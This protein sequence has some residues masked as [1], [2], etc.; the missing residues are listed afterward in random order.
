MPGPSYRPSASNATTIINQETINNIVNQSFLT[1]NGYT[2]IAEILEKIQNEGG[3]TIALGDIGNTPDTT[4][5]DYINSLIGTSYSLDANEIYFFTASTG[6]FD[7]LYLF[8]GGK[9]VTI[10]EGGVQVTALDFKPLL[11]SDRT[12][13]EIPDYSLPAGL[14]GQVH[15]ISEGKNVAPDYTLKRGI[16]TETAQEFTEATTQEISLKEVF[17][18]WDRFVHNSS[19]NLGVSS[20]PNFPGLDDSQFGISKKIWNEKKSWGYD[21]E[22]DR[23]FLTQNFGS[24]SGFVSPKSYSNFILSASLSSPSPDD[25]IMGLVIAFVKDP[26]TGYEHTISVIRNKTGYASQYT[27]AVYLN[28][29]QNRSGLF[30]LSKEILIADGTGLAPDIPEQ[31]GN[32]PGNN[33]RLFVERIGDDFTI[34]TSQFGS[35][36]IDEN[37]TLNFSL[38]DLPELERFRIG[39]KVGFSALSQPNAFFSDVYFTGFNEYILDLQNGYDAPRIFSY[40]FAD[41]LWFEDQNLTYADIWGIN[42]FLK[43]STNG[44]T[45]YLGASEVIKIS[46]STKKAQII[47]ITGSIIDLS[48]PFC[49]YC[50]LESPNTNETFTFSNEVI[51]GKARILI[52]TINEPEIIGATKIEAYNVEFQSG[53]DI[54]IEVEYNGVAVEWWFKNKG[55]NATPLSQIESLPFGIIIDETQNI[56]SEYFGSPAIVK[57]DTG[58]YIM[59]HEV[60]GGANDKTTRV[61]YSDDPDNVDFIQTEIIPNILWGG[62]VKNNSKLYLVGINNYP[63]GGQVVISESVDDGSNWSAPVTV[64]TVPNGYGGWAKSACSYIIKDNHLLI[65]MELRDTSVVRQ[66]FNSACLVIVD[67][68]DILDPVNWY[69]SNAVKLDDAAMEAEGIYNISSPG[70][71]HGIFEGSVVEKS[72]GDLIMMLRLEQEPN[73]NN[74]VYL[75]IIYNAVTPS[76]TTLSTVNNFVEMGGGNVKYTVLWDAVSAK[77]WTVANVNRYKAIDDNRM[78]AM[79]LSS[80]DDCVTWDEYKKVYGFSPTANWQTEA[81]QLGAQYA[82]FI[83]DGN[84]ILIA[85]R[86]AN[87]NAANYHNANILSLIKVKNFRDIPKK[88]FIDAAM[89][90]DENSERLQD[91]NGINLVKDQ[92]KNY[93]SPYMLIS[94]NA[95][96]PIYNNGIQFSGAEQLRL[97]HNKHLNIDNG[98]SVF[99][100]IENLQSLSGRMLSKSM[101]EGSFDR[102]PKDYFFSQEVNLAVQSSYGVYNN[103]SLGGN[104]IFSS[105]YDAVNGWIYN[106]LNGANRGQPNS[107]SQATW[108]TDHLVITTPYVTGNF[109]ELIIANRNRTNLYGNF[110]L[111]ALHV[112]DKYMSPSEMTAYMDDLNAIYNIY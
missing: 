35:E 55:Q 88:Q 13:P 78:E 104:Y 37:T 73:S 93:N 20:P 105:S 10:G 69:Y 80:D 100:V 48:N 43:S 82:D 97:I 29:Y 99:I 95:E 57:T 47:E 26:L 71:S 87:Q 22:N 33:T 46:G 102:G 17:D 107:L 21:S 59:A 1:S 64:L 58:R 42:R 67:L 39:A 92:T 7:H 66:S 110:K 61:F 62:F 108:D 2:S 74:A 36:V 5:E 72:N 31:G 18:N 23:I 81:E 84:D 8:E 16:V 15:Y 86:T 12:Q 65:G 60:I 32:W 28:F 49:N 83:I 25:D 68:T 30:P 34:K 70:E 53:I 56:G 4:I 76:N 38:T 85:G 9:P 101:A 111:K 50:N 52:N 54:Y 40:D 14:A 91:V 89:I 45:Y 77:H 44:N 112:F 11:I 98:Y 51:G 19:K 106:Y 90:I 96:K 24:Y 94:D 63:L 6:D 79:L 27:Y 3:V 75:D 103:V 109:A 41:N